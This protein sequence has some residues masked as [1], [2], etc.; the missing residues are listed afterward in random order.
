MATKTLTHGDYTVGWVCA[1]PKEQTAAL[2]MLDEKHADL[3]KQQNDPNVY[4]LG[5]VGKH[6]VVIACL[7]MGMIGNNK[8]ANVAAHMVSSFPSIKFG[9]MVGI[10]G[11]VPPNVRLGDVVVSKPVSEYSGVVQWDFGKAEQRGTFQRTGALNNPPSALLAALTKLESKHDMEGSEIP[12]HLEDLKMKWP[13]L[14]PKYIKSDSLEDVLFAA[15]HT[16]RRQSIWQAVFSILWGTIL[17]L[18]KHLL[19]SAFAPSSPE[20]SNGGTPYDMEEGDDDCRFC[21]KSKVIK[22]RPRNMRLHYGLIASGNQVIKDAIRRDGINKMLGGNVLCF[23]MEAAGLM[24]DFPCLVIRGICDYAD[25]HKNKK[26]QEHAA[27]VAAAFAKEFLSMV[28]AQEVDMMPTIKSLHEGIEK[29]SRNVDDIKQRQIIQEENSEQQ[30]R[31]QVH[32]AI[33]DWLTSTDYS[34][35]QSD[36]VGRRQEGTGNW[37]LA[38]NKFQ[39]WVN[40]PK[41]ILFCPG[42]PG[43]G[44]T[45]ATSIVVH[46]LQRK[47]RNDTSVGIAYLYCNFRQHQ[48]QNPKDLILSLLKQIIRGMPS[49][50]KYVE[51]L[52][53]EHSR[54]GTRPTFEEI[55]DVFFSVVAGFSWTFIIIDALDECNISDGAR[56]KFMST[57]FDLHDRTRANVFA[58]SRFIPDIEKEFKKR[59]AD[60][61]EIRASDEDMRRYLDGHKSQLRSFIL[62]D[63]ELEEK[64]KATIVKAADGMFLLAKLHLDSLEDKINLTQVEQALEKLPRGSDAYDQAYEEAMERVQGQ[65]RGFRDLA[66]QVLSWIICTKRP[67]TK[68]EL[69]YALATTENASSIDQGNITDI[70]LIISVCAGLITVDEESGIIRLIHYTTQEFFERMQKPYFPNMQEQI[71][72]TCITYLLFD[73]FSSGFCETIDEFEA[74]TYQSPL[75]T[76]AAYYWGDHTKGTSLEEGSLILSFLESNTRVAAASQ[77]I[78]TVERFLYG[79]EYGQRLPKGTIGLHLA[80]HFGLSRVA[81]TLLKRD[82]CLNVQ[83]NYGWTPLWI[84]ARAGQDAVVKLLLAENNIDCDTGDAASNHSPLRMAAANGHASVVELFLEKGIAN[85][86]STGNRMWETTVTGALTGAVING[87][88]DVVKLLLTKKCIQVDLKNERI[89]GSLWLAARNGHTAVVE[90][91]LGLD[92]VV[93]NVQSKY[94][95]RQTPLSVAASKGHID[96]VDLLITSGRTNLNLKDD[97]GRTPLFLASRNGHESVVKLLLTLNGIDRDATDISARTPLSAAA[98]R[99]HFTVVQ[100]LLGSGANPTLKDNYGW[101]PF[102][103]ASAIGQRNVMHLLQEMDDVRD[104]R[105]QDEDHDEELPTIEANLEPE[106]NQNDSLFEDYYIAWICTRLDEMA[107]ARGMMDTIHVDLTKHPQD[108]Y[109]YF[110]GCIS[111]HNIVVACPEFPPRDDASLMTIGSRILR[112]FTSVRA[113]LL[114]GISEGVPTKEPDIRL[115]DVV[116]GAGSSGGLVRH[117]P[118]IMELPAITIRPPVA[119]LTAISA[120]ESHHMPKESLVTEFIPEMIAKHP[121]MSANFASC[122]KPPDLLFDADYG[123]V[124]R[125]GNCDNCD[126]TQLISRPPR[127]ES[128]PFIHYG[129][130]FAIPWDGFL[131]GLPQLGLMRFGTLCSETHAFGWSEDFPALFIRGIWSYGDG[132]ANRNWQGYAAATA[133]AYA[134][135][136]LRIVPLEDILGMQAVTM[137]TR[138]PES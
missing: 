28:P 24:H 31:S 125:M 121:S 78:F 82:S 128:H 21:N 117:D 70:E 79:T 59:E 114:V 4:T 112:T 41:Q 71:A 20:H 85:P 47:F 29:I 88:V 98:A 6:N 90:L 93:L 7:P 26:W 133:A 74:R 56:S 17:A 138:S 137:A 55:T 116:V 106:S 104:K 65:K 86:K 8:A 89:Q 62:E 77:V 72:R 45:I 13:K 40:H 2:A 23:E 73:E 22:R 42:I 51:Q 25:S 9:L 38:S 5:S 53:L 18:F 54:K 103:W 67:L 33:L 12:Q 127:I 36:F 134:K 27:A 118:T 37:L 99:G 115:G 35:Q 96:V 76:Y 113:A 130:I 126:T 19:G 102:L 46:H 57:I 111:S 91:L 101:T 39:T 94:F 43:A 11:G 107:A 131:Y 52:Y 119:F 66:M 84:A 49:V 122:S 58:T 32:Q 80:A 129:K 14:I 97:K 83:N 50:P 69:Q 34:S 44:K 1:L 48:K 10:G 60:W 87:H 108:E 123:H 61:L 109:V 110:L 15:D 124:G 132:H 136:L 16:H 81:L 30:Q 3:P 120:L 64:V 92:G 105:E 135:E 68:L 63:P 100:S 95:Y 75:Y